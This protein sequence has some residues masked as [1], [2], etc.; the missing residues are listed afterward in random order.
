MPRRAHSLQRICRYAQCQNPF[1]VLVSRAKEGRGWFCSR[2][3]QRLAQAAQ[4]V[5]RP[6]AYPPCGKL[7]TIPP[8]VLRNGRGT[9]CSKTCTDLAKR[10]TTPLAERLWPYIQVCIH[11]LDCPYCCWPWT[12][13][14]WR[15]GYGRL[16]VDGIDMTTS[17]LI[18]EVWHQQHMP[19]HLCAAHHCNNPPCNNYDH[20]YAAT[21]S[22]NA[23][24]AIRAGT[25]HKGR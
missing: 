3:C 23:Q 21:A 18:W 4:Q 2:I 6:C 19:I 15:T 10:L 7:I 16:A 1:S 13:T 8:N 25:W 17:H 14:R 11:G 24:D 20:I 5:T 22:Q 9:Y 12:W